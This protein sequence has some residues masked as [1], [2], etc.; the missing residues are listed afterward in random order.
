MVLPRF[1]VKGWLHQPA[2][3]QMKS[4]LARDQPFSHQPLGARERESFVEVCLVRDEDVP[5][6]VPI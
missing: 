1:P 5:D 6:V 2:L 3:P 4:F